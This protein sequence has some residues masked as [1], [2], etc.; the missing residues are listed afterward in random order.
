MTLFVCWKDHSA[1]S[2]ENGPDRAGLE[3]SRTV[4]GGSGSLKGREIMVVG[5]R[6]V[7][8]GMESN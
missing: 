8:A 7:T 2:V 4:L 1:F 6:V 3:A 5:T